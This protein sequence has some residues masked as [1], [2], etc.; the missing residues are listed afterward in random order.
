MIEH[1]HTREISTQKRKYPS[2]ENTHSKK[3]WHDKS[4]KKTWHGNIMTEDTHTKRKYPQKKTSYDAK[5]A[6][7][8]NM[9]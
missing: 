5:Y 2:I 1:T 3:T 4:A 7:K 6:Q 8:E 9:A